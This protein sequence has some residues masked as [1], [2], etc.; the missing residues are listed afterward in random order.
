MWACVRTCLLTFFLCVH[1]NI[2]FTQDPHSGAITITMHGRGGTASGAPPNTDWTRYI[3]S[4]C[5]QHG[6]NHAKAFSDLGSQT[7]AAGNFNV[8]ECGNPPSHFGFCC[9]GYPEYIDWM[10]LCILYNGSN[11]PTPS[12]SALLRRLLFVLAFMLTFMLAF[13]LTSR[14]CIDYIGWSHLIP[15]SVVRY[16]IQWSSSLVTI[17]VNG[18]VVQRVSGAANIPQ[19]PLSVRDT[20]VFQSPPLIHFVLVV[21]LT[22]PILTGCVDPSQIK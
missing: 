1:G 19:K 11:R 18:A 7:N 15:H 12:V 9:Y 8:Y 21:E 4:S 22:R 5:Y 13:M 10:L 14:L 20:S 17:T 16:E 3:Q 2:W 6:N